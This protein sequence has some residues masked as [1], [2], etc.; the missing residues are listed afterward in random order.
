MSAGPIFYEETQGFTPWAYVLL[1]AVG[2]RPARR[3][4]AADADDRGVR[5]GDAS[6][7]VSLDDARADLGARPRGGGRVPAGPGLRRLGHA[8]A[9]AGGGSSARGAIGAS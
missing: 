7:R 6:L 2:R 3:R 4:D 5:R 9:S 1:A 8:R